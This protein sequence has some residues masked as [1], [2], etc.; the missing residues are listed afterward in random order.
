MFR[1]IWHLVFSLHPSIQNPNPFF[2]S[3][4]TQSTTVPDGIAGM[5]Q[6]IQ[7]ISIYS[8]FPLYFKSR[9]EFCAFQ[10]ELKVGRNEHFI[11]RT[12][13]SLPVCHWHSSRTHC[14]ALIFVSYSSVAPCGS[15]IPVRMF[16]VR[17]P[18]VHWVLCVCYLTTYTLLLSH[19]LLTVISKTDKA[20]NGSGNNF[21]A[22]NSPPPPPPSV[23]PRDII[24][25][26]LFV[27]LS[28][29]YCSRLLV[30]DW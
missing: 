4:R 27:I 24:E 26:I 12:V 16:L 28:W 17:W 15:W 9:I 21:T 5:I 25:I 18:V 10:H 22:R 3:G 7:R 8:S 19:S 30:E 11:R 29:Y 1:K 14:V 20:G 23:T 2:P 13:A 6:L